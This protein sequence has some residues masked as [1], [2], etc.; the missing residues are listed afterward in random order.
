MIQKLKAKGFTYNALNDELEG[1]FNGRESVVKILT[2]K[3]KVWRI[4]VVERTL[5]SAEEVKTRF[6]TLCYQFDNN[7]KYIKKNFVI[8]SG[9]IIKLGPDNFEIKANEDVSYEIL[10]NKK[11][12]QAAYYQLSDKIL[13]KSEMLW[14]KKNKYDITQEQYQDSITELM[15]EYYDDN[16]YKRYVW[17]SILEQYGKYSIAIF[18]DNENN[19]AKGED[20]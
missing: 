11:Q 12:Y 9:V 8:L 5:L 13:D 6:N 7:R 4:A 16:Q 17:I 18:Y 19:E 14:T 2:N 10:V 15:R 3:D 1:E 20:L